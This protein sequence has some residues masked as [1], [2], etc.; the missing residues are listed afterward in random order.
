MS[1]PRHLRTDP[2]MIIFGF[3]T[4]I[5]GFVVIIIGAALGLWPLPF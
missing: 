4:V 2:D 1:Y 5:V 3:L